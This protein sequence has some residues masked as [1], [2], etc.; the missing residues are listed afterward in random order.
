[1]NKS[2]KILSTILYSIILLSGLLT[3]AFSILSISG[4]INYDPLLVGKGLKNIILFSGVL[5]IIFG[6]LVF[7][8]NE[9]I[10]IFFE[11]V[12]KK[13]YSF[14]RN[15]EKYHLY[16]LLG[17]F[18]FAIFFRLFFIVRPISYQEAFNFI[19]YI[20]R[21]FFSGA[22]KYDTPNNFVL[23]SILI[24]IL[25]YIFG[26]KIGVLRIISFISGVF[27]CPAIYIAGRIYFNKFA[28][29][30]AMGIVAASPLLVFYSTT[31]TGI[32]LFLF[33][34]V[35]FFALAGY[36]KDTDEVIPWVLF[37]VL[38][39]LGFICT[40]LFFYPFFTVFLWLI[41]SILVKD[42]AMVKKLQIKKVFIYSFSSL[43]LSYIFYIPETMKNGLQ[44]ILAL[45]YPQAPSML[46]SLRS[47]LL[48]FNSSWMQWNIRLPILIG[49]VFIILII[50]SLIFLKKESKHKI[51][52]IAAI[53]ATLLLA[54]LK[55]INFQNE[56]FVFILPVF[57]LMASQGI[58]IVISKIFSRKINLKPKATAIFSILIALI[59]FSAGFINDFINTFDKNTR[60]PS[61]E[62]VMVSLKNDLTPDSKISAKPPLD[63]FFMFY[64]F[65]Y[66]VSID[67]WNRDL[68]ESN[69]FFVFRNKDSGK[70][71][72]DIVDEYFKGKSAHTFGFTEPVVFKDFELVT[73]YR[74]KA[75][76]TSKIP[77]LNYDNIKS[78]GTFENARVQKDTQEIS[79]DETTEDKLKLLQAPINIEQNTDYL[80]T[81]EIRKEGKPSSNVFIDFFGKNYDTP[82][83][84]FFISP[85]DI[86][87]SYT[88]F[89]FVLNSGEIPP[90]T[91]TFFRIFTKVS[92]QLHVKD[93]KVLKVLDN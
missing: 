44:K 10:S 27:L 21:P 31:S 85:D 67:D 37:V 6:I 16:A 9:S 12:L 45:N 90:D 42:S 49:P 2:S 88:K 13:I 14:F 70:N 64:G 71:N 25:H 5:I 26:D 77:V 51:P 69:N 23:N 32:S 24:S 92:E 58:Y 54:I 48:N 74:M 47:F 86:N 53:A 59:I 40:P 33:I 56:A 38:S 1:M 75:L 17:L 62:E 46:L 84:E 81:F 20:A 35:L 65:K 80:I 60:P 18:I 36:L 91:Q 22:L 52:V 68:Y 76:E 34:L 39:V 28:A 7:L 30:I 83:Q 15:E 43:V 66:G 73:V 72:K 11:R 87:I 79:L 63:Y 50:L 8:K 93:I 19:N 55:R 29:L 61:A 89:R 4:I 3:I 41:I 82:A 78:Q 57:I